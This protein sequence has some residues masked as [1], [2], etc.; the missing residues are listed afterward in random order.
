MEGIA[1]L[2]DD[3]LARHGFA[4][5]VD[6]RR[7]QWTRWF[8]CESNFSLLLV[9]SAGGIYTLAEEVVAPG[10]TPVTGGKRILA[11]FQIA[12]TEDLCVTLSQHFSPRSPL[13]ERLASGCCFLRFATVSDGIYRQ[14]ICKTLNQWLSS[15]AEVATGL[16]RDFAAMP[17]TTSAGDGEL[18]PWAL[19]DDSGPPALPA[20]F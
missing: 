2:V 11:V 8:R 14:G 4:M 13:R 10:E 20:G 19:A 15:S 1:R 18:R 9:P 5:S 12:E 3:S 7:L 6:Y 17:E 16:V